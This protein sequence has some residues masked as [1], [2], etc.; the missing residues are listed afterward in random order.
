MGIPLKQAP[1]HIG[2]RVTFVSIDN[3]ILYISGSVPGTFPL[4]AGREATTTPA[5][6]IGFFDLLQDLFSRH[7]DKRL[8]QGAITTN[9]QV[10]FDT[11]GINAAI[12]AENQ[13]FLVFVER[14]FIFMNNL[15]TAVRI[16]VKQA[17]NNLFFLNGFRKNFRNIPGFY[18]KIANPFRI[19]DDNRPPLA[20]TVTAG[21]SDLYLTL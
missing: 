20:K 18:L 10:V 8:G 16:T 7:P 15:F 11:L 9:C 6:E 5:P 13:P 12:G 1:V 14:N 3:D 17:L 4:D 2:S 21:F 19:F